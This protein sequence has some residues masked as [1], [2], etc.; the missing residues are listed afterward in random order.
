MHTT[1][2]A[3]SSFDENRRGAL[4]EGLL[5]DFV[6]L[7]RDILP[8]PTTALNTLK[9]EAVYFKGQRYKP[10]QQ[11]LLGLLGKAIIG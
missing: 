2:A 6:V 8:M 11:G 7:S 3:Y 4:R 5:C 10:K 1:W 9:I